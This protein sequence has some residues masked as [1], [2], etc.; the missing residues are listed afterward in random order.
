[1]NKAHYSIAI[2]PD[3]ERLTLDQL[4]T[5][6]IASILSHRISQIG[7]D[8]IIYLPEE[9]RYVDTS[10]LDDSI[11]K[12]LPESVIVRNKKGTFAKLTATAD[13]VHGEINTNNIPFDILRII[14]VDDATQTIHAELVDPN[15]MAKPV[16][17][18]FANLLD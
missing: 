8:S 4:S 14:S 3:D 17:E 11:K 1:M 5:F 12:K 7:K 9:Y 6:E 10:N 15:K 18:Y 16:L 2:I 13:I